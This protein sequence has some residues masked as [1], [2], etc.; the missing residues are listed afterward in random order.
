MI[1]FVQIEPGIVECTR[2]ARRLYTPSPPDKCWCVC[3]HRPPCTGACPGTELIALNQQLGF[4]ACVFCHGT[5]A[6][7]NQLG[8]DGCQEHREELK[9]EIAANFQMMAN[10]VAK[11]IDALDKPLTPE[12]LDQVRAGTLTVLSDGQKIERRNAL[13]TMAVKA[14]MFTKGAA[15]AAINLAAGEFVPDAGD[16]IGSLID[17]SIRRAR[18]KSASPLA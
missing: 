9:A 6:K 5:A 11:Q 10:G 12:Q 3:D 18:V 8:P 1:R 2:C 4:T 7:M 14:A 16:R 15:H 17:E 13:A